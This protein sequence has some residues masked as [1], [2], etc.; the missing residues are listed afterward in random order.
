LAPRKQQ[1]VWREDSDNIFGA[2][3]NR[4]RLMIGAPLMRCFL[5]ITVPR[6]L[7]CF[8]LDSCTS[9][10][11]RWRF[12]LALSRYLLSNSEW[13]T[14]ASKFLEKKRMRSGD[15]GLGMRSRELWLGMT[16]PWTCSPYPICTLLL[17]LLFFIIFYVG[18]FRFSWNNWM[19][20][21]LT[22]KFTKEEEIKMW[23]ETD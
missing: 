14:T 4:R 1:K 13:L 21:N 8:S 9:E 10:L 20:N 23:N 11:L 5:L 17:K 16:I 2:K 12:D 15:L 19:S 7:P 6:F 22:K 18:C 3:Y